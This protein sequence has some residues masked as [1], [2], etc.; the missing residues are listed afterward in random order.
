ME[1]NVNV[2]V[3]MDLIN[4]IR[5]LDDEGAV[6]VSSAIAAGLQQRTVKKKIL[7]LVK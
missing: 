5:N 3:V 6:I 4:V 7:S 1:Q 2:K